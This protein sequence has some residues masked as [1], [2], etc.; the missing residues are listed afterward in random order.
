MIDEADNGRLGTINTE[1]E[2]YMRCGSDI[3]PTDKYET[4]G[5]PNN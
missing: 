3:Y 1:T 5:I 2:N 4:V